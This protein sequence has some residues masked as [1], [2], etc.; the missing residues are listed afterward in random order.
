MV[1][2][3]GM[4]GW[5]ALATLTVSVQS[6]D[7]LILTPSNFDSEIGGDI[8][9]L[10]EFFAPWCGHCKHLAPEYEIVATTFAKHPIKIAS[11]DADS[12]KELARRF[13]VSG[14]PTIK[15]FPAGSKTGEAYSG[16]RSAPDFVDFI[17]KKIGIHARIKENP[18]LVTILTDENFDSIVKDA[19]KNVLVEFYYPK[20]PTWKELAPKYEEVAKT[21]DGEDDVVI[22]KIDADDYKVKAG[23]YGV[24][25]VQTHKFFSKENKAGEDFVARSTMD[26]V[27]F[28]NLKC[29]TERK[30]G[31]G[32]TDKAGRIT[33]L[34]DLA[35]KFM[36]NV[37]ERQ[38]TLQLTQRLIPSLEHR[39]KEF[40][41]FY[42]IPMKR[43]LEKGDEAYGKTEVQRLNRVL[44][45]G[46]V[47]AKKKGEFHKRINI[48]SQFI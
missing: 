4:V 31:G 20:L 19:T 33:E 17:N 30:V 35:K 29:E 28:V 15:Y 1:G 9:A 36:T 37:E 8:P 6:S 43:I 18:T 24:L 22:A 21:F 23:E 14:F 45:S 46:S 5:L 27:N 13:D 10:V 34:D 42:E 32:Y 26:Y 2:M 11:V 40:A 12:H 44:E 47:G 3:V 16:G 48:A 25:N 7:V 38:Q 41:K 39:N